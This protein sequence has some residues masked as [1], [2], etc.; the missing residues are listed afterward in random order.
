MDIKNRVKYYLGN[1]YEIF[2]NEQK[3]EYTVFLNEKE[4]ISYNKI[5]LI[6]R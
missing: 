2:K 4:E 1:L 5:Q 3:I 6:N